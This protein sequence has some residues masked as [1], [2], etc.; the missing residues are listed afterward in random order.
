MKN[1]SCPRYESRTSYTD[2]RCCFSSEGSSRYVLSPKQK[3]PQKE[4]AGRV[5]DTVVQSEIEK[6]D[7]LSSRE[8]VAAIVART[9]QYV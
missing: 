8:K 5:S 9:V 7:V 4:F 1:T 3:S 2:E 6:G